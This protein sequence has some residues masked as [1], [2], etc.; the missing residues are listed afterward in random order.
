M[1]AE[2]LVS[3][4]ADSG[5]SGVVPAVR[6]LVDL[7]RVGSEGVLQG[8]ERLGTQLVAVAYEECPAKL[9]MAQDL[10]RHLI[11][12]GGFYQMVGRG[13]RLDPATYKLM[14]R[15]YDYTDAT[16][17]FPEAFVRKIVTPRKTREGPEPPP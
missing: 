17:L 11:E 12:T 14:F 10:F 6:V 13:T 5:I 7:R 2:R 15:V 16:R 9:A 3:G 4:H 8:S 1:N